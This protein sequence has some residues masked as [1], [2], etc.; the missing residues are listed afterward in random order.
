MCGSGI[1]IF[2]VDGFFE[3]STSKS[4]KVNLSELE[5]NPV[6]ANPLS[7]SCFSGSMSLKE[8]ISLLEESRSP[9][10]LLSL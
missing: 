7:Y 5:V 1:Q 9:V 10:S 8:V 4:E 6:E 3:V 2:K